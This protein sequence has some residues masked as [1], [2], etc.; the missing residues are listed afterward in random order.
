MSIPIVFGLILVGFPNQGLFNDASAYLAGKGTVTPI[1][2]AAAGTLARGGAASSAAA[3]AA[4]VHTEP[5]TISKNVINSL[6]KSAEAKAVTTSPCTAPCVDLETVKLGRSIFATNGLR[7]L[8][9]VSPFKV[10]GGQVSL[11]SPKN[12]KLVAAAIT[13]R[14]IEH[15]VV[16]DLFKVRDIKAGES[17]FRTDLGE[18]ISGTNPFTKSHDTVSDFTDLLLWNNSNSPMTFRDDDAAAMNIIFR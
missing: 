17:L 10:I 2:T 16:V 13:T 8:A 11:T 3:A 15:A 12:I 18:V 7:P 1:A 5:T 14:G 9:D 6:V 4:T